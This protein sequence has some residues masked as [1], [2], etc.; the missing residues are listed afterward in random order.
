MSTAND[1]L[2]G[3]SRDLTENG[4]A[5]LHRS[6]A[7]MSAQPAT[8]RSL[9][10]A[11]V[12]LAAAVEVLMK[13][14]L[15]R[16]HWTLI[17]ADPD[18]ATATQM[19]AGTA[20]TVTPE[21]AIKRLEN[22][23]GVAM[24][25]GGHADRVIEVATLRNRAIHFAMVGIAPAG[26]QSPLGHGLDFVLWFL[27]TQFRG[28][29]DDDVQELVEESIERLTTE[30]GQLKALVAARLAS[31]GDELGMAGLCVECP[32]CRQATLML[33][34]GDVS[35]CVFCLWKP[36]DGAECAAE[37]ADAV[38][39]TSQY[40]A[41][42]DGGDWPVHLCTACGET[43]MVEGIEQLLPNPATMH[44]GEPPC[45]WKAPG[46]W[47]CFS[48]GTTADRTELD[49]C[50]RCDALTE[51]GDDDGLPVCGEC[52]ADVLRD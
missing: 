34:D 9:S 38:L 19:L 17:C 18:K 13:A 33:I 35:R 21:Q 47:G 7:E 20:K 49:R 23:A 48:C 40:Q 15:V 37:Y 50:T 22:V 5:F 45:D 42:K 30:V 51:T 44:R 11:M 8:M 2:A 12:D 52:W 25:A 46:Y 6:V 27:G 26:L 41:I 28:Q 24:K 36:V 4:L 39:G 1:P 32:R 14:R 16:E 3:L 29:G 43:S 31:I 10:V